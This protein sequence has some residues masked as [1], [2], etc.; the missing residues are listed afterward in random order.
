MACRDTLPE[1]G[2]PGLQEAYLGVVPGREELGE[3]AE[4]GLEGIVM[5]L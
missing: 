1:D 3:Q 4:D 2:Y 5:G